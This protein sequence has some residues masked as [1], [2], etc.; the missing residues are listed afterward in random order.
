MAKKRIYP[1]REYYK[2]LFEEY[3]ANNTNALL[4]V[5]LKELG[6]KT[7]EDL[8][9]EEY[10]GRLQGDCGVTYIVPINKEQAREWRLDDGIDSKMPIRNPNY[11][12]QSMTIKEIMAK[13][14]LEDLKLDDTFCVFSYMT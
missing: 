11:N 12:T 3:Y 1:T 2:P 10:Q 14:M 7:L 4:Q 9:Y 13:K 6:L 5:V 8:H